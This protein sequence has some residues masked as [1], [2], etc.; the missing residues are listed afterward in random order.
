MATKSILR[1]VHINK[2][3]M[4][5][6]LVSALSNAENKGSKDVVLSRN[7]EEVKAENIKSLFKDKSEASR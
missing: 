3:D 7:L 6:G 1:N 4:A 5:K 2:K